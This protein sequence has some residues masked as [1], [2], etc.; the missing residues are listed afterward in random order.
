[1]SLFETRT[2]TQ[3]INQLLPVGNFL[4]STFFKNVQ[5]PTGE[6]ID[7]VIKKGKRRLAP[8]VSPKVAGKVITAM[9]KSVLTYKPGYVK[10]KRIFTPKT[11]LTPETVFYA[12]TLT[13]VQRLANQIVTEQQDQ[14]NMIDRRVEWMAAK[15][16][17]TGS[18]SIIGDGIEEVV[19]FGMSGDHIV[20]LTGTALW[21]DA[22]S[23]PRADVKKWKTKIQKDCGIA[24][25]TMI[26]GLDAIEAYIN[27]PNTKDS[28][29][30]RRIDNGTIDPKILPGGVTYYGYDKELGI[31][32]YSYTEWYFD[33]DSG[34]DEDLMPSD[35]II[36]GSDMAET[37]LAYGMIQDLS[38][39]YA[40]KYFSKSWVTEDPSV[41]YL[42]AQ[43]AP[44]TIP[45]QIDA[46][47]SAKVV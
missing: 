17:T 45:T 35:S 26:G 19:D 1:M 28:F 24:P 6:Y 22:T 27:N 8:F 15:S 46:F 2:L 23:K 13:P 29:D 7:V 4:T 38:A 11:A 39:L 42:L 21:S 20:T 12:D 18:V 34:I 44:L 9:G 40:T 30:L 37:V 31:D 47:M 5:E 3:T 41:R 25:N 32:I 43:S 36:L 10:D 33:E 16:L 14:V